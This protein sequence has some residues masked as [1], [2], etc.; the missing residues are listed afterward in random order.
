MQG[1]HS[2]DCLVSDKMVQVFV[3]ADQTYCVDV[4]AT[5]SVS[6]FLVAFEDAA[7]RI[8]LIWFRCLIGRL[9]VG[10]VRGAF[11]PSIA[12]QVQE[13]ATISSN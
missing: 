11:Q 9:A 6:D 7:G 2:I 3:R 1:Q 12:G 8:L 10:G 13:K 5:S 4:P